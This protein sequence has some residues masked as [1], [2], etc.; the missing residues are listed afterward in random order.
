MQTKPQWNS[1]WIPD[2][3]Q[4]RKL[5]S[6]LTRIERE[7]YQPMPTSQANSLLDHTLQTHEDWLSPVIP[8]HDHFG[9]TRK[10]RELLLTAVS[11]ALQ[12]RETSIDGTLHCFKHFRWKKTRRIPLCDCDS[13]W[14]L[15]RYGSK[16]HLNERSC[17]AEHVFGDFRAKRRGIWYEIRGFFAGKKHSF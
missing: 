8:S 17:I 13:R 12:L 3:T 14:K 7:N 5:A 2:K 6:P 1:N 11:T 9:V 16:L 4:P 10:H 15:G